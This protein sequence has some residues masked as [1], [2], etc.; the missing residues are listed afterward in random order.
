LLEVGTG[1]HP[2]LTGRENIYLNGSIL[3]MNK[4]EIT[5]KL[6]EIITFSEIE[7]F[8][9]TPVKRYSSGMYVRLAFA[10]AAHLDPEVLVVD[11]V[12]AVGDAAFQSKCLEKMGEVSTGGRT[13]LFVSHN[14]NAV[15]K[16]CHRGI[17]LS[18]GKIQCEGSAASVVDAYLS[19]LRVSNATMPSLQKTPFSD[20][21]VKINGAAITNVMRW[22]RD[23][24]L[25]ITLGLRAR[26]AISCP[27]I[28]LAFYRY[29]TLKL[30][31]I[32]SDANIKADPKDV[33]TCWE[34]NWTIHE[35]GLAAT[36]I[37]ADMGIRAGPLSEY[38][39]LWQHMCE[40]EIETSER[41]E[42]IT[43]DSIIFPEV[44]VNVNR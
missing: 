16:V 43:R 31:A 14:M 1:F 40:L 36:S 30:F 32:R 37:Y 22:K 13:I 7:K 3:G 17:Y 5:R 44:M 39:Y 12:L 29:D 2:D 10:V 34:F 25:E 33:R 8:V 21:D 4:Q 38:I 20:L 41:K 15:Q 23:T 6:D 9:D 35:P 19:S 28:D 26:E 42:E 24:A 11:E 27:R 18:N